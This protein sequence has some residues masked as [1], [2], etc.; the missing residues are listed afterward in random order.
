[1]TKSTMTI[2]KVVPAEVLIALT[3]LGGALL[4]APTV[5]A[6]GFVVSPAQRATAEKV[7]QAG[8]ALSELA[9]NAP[10]SH[11]VQR[12][13]TLW[14]ISGLF[15]KSPWRWPELWGMNL[16]DIKNPHLIYPGDVIVLDKS[17]GQWRLSVE[18]PTTRL[19]PTVRATP[20]DAAA[21][22]SIR[23]RARAT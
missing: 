13:D 2:F 11:G 9:E 23:Q 7:A 21:I 17:D 3:A 8:V 20:L 22:P 16:D 18:R 5:S 19:S 15:L 6:Q 10:A 4:A 1:M 14:A 12:G